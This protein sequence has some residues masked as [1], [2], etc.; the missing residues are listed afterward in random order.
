MMCMTFNFFKG[1][2]NNTAQF[3]M[4]TVVTCNNMIDTHKIHDCR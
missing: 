4:K 3:F 1:S 2:P